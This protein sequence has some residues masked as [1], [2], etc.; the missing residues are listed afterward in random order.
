MD[1][2]KAILADVVTTALVVLACL[3]GYD[4]F[5]IEPRHGPPSPAPAPAPGGDD[6]D[7]AKLGRDYAPALVA[8]YSDAYEAAAALLEKGATMKQVQDSFVASW[9]KARVAKFEALVE[10]SF[11]RVLPEGTE[12]RDA[13]HRAAVVKL[14]RDF[15][16]GLKGGR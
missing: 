16:R 3:V 6:V 4:H 14:Y 2:A 15:A 12:P 10:P 7:G 13:A 11:L 1:K 9:Q 5:V 8:V